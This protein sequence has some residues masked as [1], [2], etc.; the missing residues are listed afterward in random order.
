MA[1]AKTSENLSVCPEVSQRFKSDCLCVGIMINARGRKV[2]TNHGGLGVN[3]NAAGSSFPCPAFKGPSGIGASQHFS[4][5][6]PCRLLPQRPSWGFSTGKLED[7]AFW[8]C[9]RQSGKNRNLQK[10]RIWPSQMQLCE[11]S[12]HRFRHSLPKWDDSDQKRKKW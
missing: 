12:D 11:V 2:T 1:I 10:M 4:H 5:V 6:Q 8:L 3:S 7:P 9:S